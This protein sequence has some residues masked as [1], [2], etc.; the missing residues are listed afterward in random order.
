MD[1]ARGG[2]ARAPAVIV[3]GVAC[4]GL[5]VG[6]HGG[7]STGADVAPATTAAASDAAPAKEAASA[8]PADAAIEDAAP[9]VVDAGP[10]APARWRRVLQ[11]GDS[12]VGYHRG[13]SWALEK[14]FK[15]A[16]VT[17]FSQS[18]TSEAIQTLSEE[19]K[20][21]KLIK[22]YKP[23]AVI[24]NLGT[25]NLTVPHPEAYASN[26]RA[27]VK[28]MGGLDCYWIS[29]P[30]PKWKWNP[31]VIGVIRDNA[32]PCLFFDSTPLVLE[33]QSDHIHPT[34]RG[35]EAWATAFWAFM[36]DGTVPVAPE[37]ADAGLLAPPR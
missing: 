33:I 28:K 21:E 12:M 1:R 24:L 32:A 2:A 18:W 31:E 34:D 20:V 5:A 30:T 3:V 11:M 22:H 15:A 13:L 19:D 7:G 10:P 8:T 27:I 6:C 16:G 25:N 9:D 17:F 29:P 4:A 36:V 14:R 23:D 26:V 35:G 37:R